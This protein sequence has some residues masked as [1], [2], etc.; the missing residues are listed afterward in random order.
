MANS[1]SGNTWRLDTSGIITPNLVEIVAMEWQPTAI[2]QTL[3]IKNNQGDI[4]WQKT[5]YG[6]IDPTFLVWTP[7]GGRTSSSFD[8]FN[9]FQITGG[10]LFVTIL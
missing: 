1:G 2:G 3:I 6:D 10:V 4:V 7:P 5:A 8:G 9:L